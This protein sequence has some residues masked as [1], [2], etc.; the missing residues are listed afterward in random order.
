M[1]QLISKYR[2]FVTFCNATYARA[3]HG[4]K[5]VKLHQYLQQFS[6]MLVLAKLSLQ[7]RKCNR[8][9]CE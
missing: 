4:P 3:F 2:P 7:C 9:N 6:V 8:H 1:S 5:F